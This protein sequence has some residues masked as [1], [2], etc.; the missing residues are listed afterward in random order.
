M[1]VTT[2]PRGLAPPRERDGSANDC[3]GYLAGWSAVGDLAPTSGMG[4]MVH[5]QAPNTPQDSRIWV[6]VCPSRQPQGLVVPA[7][8]GLQLLGAHAAATITRGTAK[9]A[10]RIIGV[11]LYAGRSVGEAIH[12]GVEQEASKA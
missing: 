1:R 5:E 4:G 9:T 8:Q 7:L 10:L 12:D 3:R 11:G 6:P 2:V